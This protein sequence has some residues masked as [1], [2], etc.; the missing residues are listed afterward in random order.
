MMLQKK[1][2]VIFVIKA[3]L[4]QLEIRLRN[5]VQSHIAFLINEIETFG[6]F[7]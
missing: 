3:Q 7:V 5:L 4:K 1:H 6:R 2:E